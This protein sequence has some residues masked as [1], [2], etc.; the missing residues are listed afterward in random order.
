[1]KKLKSWSWNAM[2]GCIY[3]QFAAG[4]KLV[5]CVSSTARKSCFWAN[6]DCLYNWAVSLVLF[7]HL[8]CFRVRFEKHFVMLQI[9]FAPFCPAIFDAQRRFVCYNLSIAL[10]NIQTESLLSPGETLMCFF[11]QHIATSSVDRI[12]WWEHS[13]CK[14]SSPNRLKLVQIISTQHGQLT[15]TRP[16]CYHRLHWFAVAGSTRSRCSPSPDNSAS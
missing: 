3:K 12:A 7:H 11:H 15:P 16:W 1:M 13:D 14:T 8:R 10:D 4:F 5:Y 9:S 2:R 6:W